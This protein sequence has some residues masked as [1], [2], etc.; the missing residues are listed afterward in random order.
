MW[1]IN[2]STKITTNRNEPL[3]NAICVFGYFPVRDHLSAHSVIPAKAGIQPSR[4]ESR[5][6]HTTDSVGSSWARHLP[7]QV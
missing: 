7:P 1:C 6:S 4:V 5:S 2:T 3:K